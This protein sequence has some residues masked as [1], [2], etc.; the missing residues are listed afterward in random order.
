MFLYP[1]FFRLAQ[2]HLCATVPIRLRDGAMR[3]HN[4]AADTKEK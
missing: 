4:P 2:H 3:G 1:G